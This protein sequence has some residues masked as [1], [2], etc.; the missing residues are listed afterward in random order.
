MASQPLKRQKLDIEE[1]SEDSSPFDILPNEIVEIII[2]MAMSTMNTQERYNF[3]VD[4][5]PKVMR[6]FRVIANQKAMWRDI[7]PFEM[8]PNN[9]AEIPIQMVLSGIKHERDV[10]LIE[11]LA[12]ISSRFKVLVALKSLWKGNVVI[13]GRTEHKK[14][15]IRQYV[16][17]NT[18]NICIACLFEPDTLLPSDITTLATR[19]PNLSRLS[20]SAIRL[21]LWPDFASPWTSLK[22]L[23]LLQVRAELV[24]AG[25]GVNPNLF[26]NVELHQSLPNLEEFSIR[27]SCDFVLP[28]MGQCKYLHSICLGQGLYII[29]GLPHGLKHLSGH[30]FVLHEDDPTIFNMDRESLEAQFEHCEITDN[31]QFGTHN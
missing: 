16:N 8:L 26:N 7:S 22:K 12:K 23:R 31:I 20:L 25:W 27:A 11:D 29:T 13:N 24:T 17:D 15:V 6:R 19:C 14:Q 9:L 30:K 1:E 5:L 28:D 18:T 4:V 10:F 2:K 21:E 3:L